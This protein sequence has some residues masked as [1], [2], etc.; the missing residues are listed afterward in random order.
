M[1]V[2]GGVVV[3]VVTANIVRMEG[4]PLLAPFSAQIRCLYVSLSLSDV[5]KTAW[6][7]LKTCME[8][9]LTRNVV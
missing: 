9:E 8:H 4:V 1:F 3:V 7:S 5:G 6:R 2:Y